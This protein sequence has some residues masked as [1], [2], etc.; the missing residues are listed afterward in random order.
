MIVENM[1]A[2]HRR[3]GTATRKQ[4]AGF[5]RLMM[6]RCDGTI[7]RIRES[8]QWLAAHPNPA[9]DRGPDVKRRAECIGWTLTAPRIADNIKALAEMSAEIA[10]G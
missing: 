3:C 10:R 7:E 4:K 1:S 6:D 9:R 2:K 5:I 8:E